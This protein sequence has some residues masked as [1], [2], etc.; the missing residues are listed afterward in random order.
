[1][2]VC[3]HIGCRIYEKS[4][5]VQGLHNLCQNISEPFPGIS[6]VQF[7]F[8]FINDLVQGHSIA[9]LRHDRDRQ[10]GYF[11]RAV[12]VIIVQNGEF[13]SAIFIARVAVF[14]IDQRVG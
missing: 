8:E 13:F 2:K 5:F 10:V 1:M 9:K 14:L 12:T 4:F 6:G 3:A 7:Y 11:N